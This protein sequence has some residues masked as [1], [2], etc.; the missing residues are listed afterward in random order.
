V[1]KGEGLTEE[2]VKQAVQLSTEKYCSVAASL[3][4]EIVTTF[5]I[6]NVLAVNER[7]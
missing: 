7:E 1:V 2:A 5:E 6:E 3:K 4:A